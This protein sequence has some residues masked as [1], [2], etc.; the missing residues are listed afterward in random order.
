MEK[1]ANERSAKLEITLAEQRA[2]N[3]KVNAKLRRAINANNSYADCHVSPDGL[4]A[5]REAI[6]AK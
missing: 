5:L 1:E 3:A 2:N 4:F 6:A